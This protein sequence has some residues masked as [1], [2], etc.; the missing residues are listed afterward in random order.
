MK[1]IEVATITRRG[2]RDLRCECGRKFRVTADI[3]HGTHS[4]PTADI[5]RFK[6]NGIDLRCN[7]AR[8]LHARD[9]FCEVK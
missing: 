8:N 4:H 6:L 5:L 9:C 3:R 1:T 2:P 7:P